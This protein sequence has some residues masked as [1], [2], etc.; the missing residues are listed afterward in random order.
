M[1]IFWFSNRAMAEE[2]QDKWLVYWYICG[3]NLESGN[4]LASEDPGGYATQD[5]QEM[6]SVKFSP[7]VKVLIQ[8][9]GSDRW[10]TESIPDY[11]IGR[12]LYDSNGWHYQGSFSD[13][14]M[15][16]EKTLSNFLKY[17]K[18]EIEPDFKPDHR[19][20][21]FWD[22]GTFVTVC[23]DERYNESSLDLNEIYQAFNE[24]FPHAS[25]DN[26]PFEIIGFDACLRATYENANNLY[27]FTKYLIASQETESGVGWS[28]SNWIQ[29]IMENPSLDGKNLSK[30]ICDSSINFLRNSDDEAFQAESLKATFSVMDLS[31]S[32]MSILRND[33]N[34]FGKTLLDLTKKY[35]EESCALFDRSA[36]GKKYGEGESLIDLWSFAQDLKLHLEDFDDIDDSLKSRIS[37]A[38]D[39]L[40]DSINSSVVY[41]VYGNERDFSHGISFYYPLR[42]SFMPA[43]SQGELDGK[44]IDFNLY[45]LQKTVPKFTKQIGMHRLSYWWKADT[46]SE[47]S[48]SA[49]SFDISKSDTSRSSRV[50]NPWQSGDI[51]ILIGRKDLDATSEND[52]YDDFYM[53]YGGNY[54]YEFSIQLTK[55]Q[56][57]RLSNVYYSVMFGGDEGTI[58]FGRKALEEFIGD[59]FAHLEKYADEVFDA[60]DLWLDDSDVSVPMFDAYLLVGFNSDINQDWKNGYFS[61]QFNGEWLT[62]DD[63]FIFPIVDTS[64]PD[65]KD[66]NGNVIQWGYTSYSVPVLINNIPHTLKIVYQNSDKQYTII[67]ASR[68]DVI[69]GNAKRSQSNRGYTQLKEGDEVVPIFVEMLVGTNVAKSERTILYQDIPLTYDGEMGHMAVNWVG[70]N[71][72]TIGKNPVIGT[73]MIP[74]VPVTSEYR[75]MFILQDVFGNGI[76][77][78]MVQFNSDRDYLK[79]VEYDPENW[80][81]D[82]KRVFYAS[83]GRN[84]NPKLSIEEIRQKINSLR[85]VSWEE[86]ESAVSEY[87]N[88]FVEW[89]L[90][91]RRIYQELERRKQIRE[92]WNK[93]K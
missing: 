17:G 16:D 21:V 88:F 81:E 31:K 20:F 45:D 67:G 2:S 30:I 40:R 11:T 48:D 91:D 56:M 24:N 33:Y 7:N 77:S 57:K 15:G 47:Q 34:A 73:K 1:T 78:E 79:G 62:L 75:L 32:K 39:K 72:F 68:N 50:F 10:Q 76:K 4:G 51:P 61:K 54:E 29:A 89:A 44:K 6:M 74:K 46:Q 93:K 38:S 12:Y 23:R 90:K 36:T 43:T 64:K 5:L 87:D 9:G 66:S 85:G 52:A 60:L 55:D 82:E 27:G 84:D 69:N 58:R 22:H 19:I 8:T 70:A 14:D 28:Y 53:E 83:L 92:N 42:E 86:F 18:E 59:D 49:L 35:P 25:A 37:D 80:N 65:V 13:T 71:K 3:S 63:H 26:P 41:N